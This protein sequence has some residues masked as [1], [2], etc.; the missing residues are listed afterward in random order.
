MCTQIPCAAIQTTKQLFIE[1]HGIY[2]MFDMDF[3]DRVYRAVGLGARLLCVV[4]VNEKYRIKRGIFHTKYRVQCWVL[5]VW[6]IL[7]IWIKVVL[8]WT[9]PNAMGSLPWREG[10][11]LFRKR[12]M[13]ICIHSARCTLT[14]FPILIRSPFSF[15]TVLFHNSQ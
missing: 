6:C 7:V 8:C 15:V 1:V 13:Y 9:F 12:K 3:W 4:D 14:Y 11:L 5:N 10:V 2:S